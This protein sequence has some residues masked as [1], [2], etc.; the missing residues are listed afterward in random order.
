MSESA[1]RWSAVDRYIE[2]LF[3]PPEAV[4]TQALEDSAA[5]GL[6]DIHVSPNEGKLLYMLAKL[7]GAKRILEIGLLGGYS[8]LW[9]AKAL[10]SG[11]KLLTLEIELKHAEVARKNFERAGIQ[12]KIEIRVGPALQG[13]DKLVQE[14]ATPFDLVF[15]DA[16]KTAYPAYLDWALK[17][18]RSGSLILADNVVRDG[19]VALS[20][21][22]DA[23]V[24]AVK[25]FNR[26]LAEDPRLEAT[27]LPL[28]RDALDGLAL[29]RVK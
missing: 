26:K 6:P 25:V 4:F 27:L 2:A 19:K 23:A 1:E 10:P 7:S 13:L 17:L 15:I 5:A 29:A 9:L 3:T 21:K 22:G 20:E 24:E 16:D 8:A 18:T 14:R 28:M 12:D 11:G